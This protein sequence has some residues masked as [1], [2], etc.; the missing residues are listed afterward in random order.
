MNLESKKATAQR[1]RFFSLRRYLLRSSAG[2]SARDLEAIVQLKLIQLTSKVLTKNHVLCISPY[3]TGTTFLAGCY[4]KTIASHEPLRYATLRYINDCQKDLFYRRLRFLGLS[5]EC[6]GH[7]SAYANEFKRSLPGKV[8]C[9]CIGR[10]PSQWITSVINYWKALHEEGFEKAD[11]IDRL[12]W[13]PAIG[14]SLYGFFENDEL[15][16][17]KIIAGLERFYLRFVENAIEIPGMVFV[18]LENLV[19]RLP[20]IDDMVG[21]RS[22]PGKAWRRS[23]KIGFYNYE[24]EECD[25]RYQELISH[26]PIRQSSA[27]NA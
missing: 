22:K 23:N 13:R 26:M 10:P 9:I 15:R 24:S 6:S 11:Y 16:R 12:F 25:R 7:F 17:E 1:E 21:V 5:L 8:R 27:I 18:P 4:S 3:K 14:E 19:E 20:E 2:R